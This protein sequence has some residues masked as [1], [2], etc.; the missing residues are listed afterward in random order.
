MGRLRVYCVTEELMAVLQCRDGKLLKVEK[1][2]V[3]YLRSLG[4]N[5][6]LSSLGDTR[7][8]VFLRWKLC[9]C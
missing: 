7:S 5:I 1:H 3:V 2:M 4:K 9:L 8:V 6:V